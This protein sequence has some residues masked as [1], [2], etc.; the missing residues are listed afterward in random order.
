MVSVSP[1]S[2][3]YPTPT[4][5]PAQ[6]L[7]AT[8][9]NDSPMDLEPPG[10]PA[11]SPAPNGLQEVPQGASAAME[12]NQRT[13][14]VSVKW[15]AI[16]TAPAPSQQHNPPLKPV[17]PLPPRPTDSPMVPTPSS[18]PSLPSS[19]PPKPTTSLS[20]PSARHLFPLPAP[21][22][23]SSNMAALPE[24]ADIKP[25]L[26][27]KHET[28]SPPT[29]SSLPLKPELPVSPPPQQD[30]VKP[31]DSPDSS[32]LQREAST[33]TLPSPNPFAS[34]STSASD[35]GDSSGRSTPR[36]EE[37]VTRGRSKSP[38]KPRSGSAD[39]PRKDKGKKVKK[40]EPEAQLIGH[41]PN[42]NDEALSSFIEV[43]IVCITMVGLGVLPA[44]FRAL[45]ESDLMSSCSTGF[46]DNEQACGE[47]SSC[48]NRLMQ[49]ECV[50]GDCK[51]GENCQNQ[52]FQ[53]KQYAKIDIVKTEKKGYG[54]RTSEDLPADTFVYE[55]VGEVIG[56]TAFTKRMKDYAAGGI[57]HFYFM[58]LDRE[59]FIDATKKGGKGR[60]LNHSC[61]PN[62]FVAKWT[63][64]KKMRMGI[65]TKRDIK[66][67]EE[68]TFNYNVDRYGHVAQPCYCG[69][70]NCVGFI[71]GKTQT[72]IGGMDDLY[73]D[74]LGITEEVE[75]LGLR[76][77]KK[78]KSKKLD[79]DFLPDLKPI[80]LDE[81]PKVSAAVRQAI[82][83]RRILEKLLHRIQ[84]T[85]DEDVRNAL[86]RL[87]GF[88]L[89][90]HILKEYPNDIRI[91]TLDL[92]ILGNW[93]LKTR[94]K[95][96]D[97]KI[98][99][100]VQRCA[101]MME[102][103]IS[104]MATAVSLARFVPLPSRDADVLPSHQLL[105]YWDSLELG[106]R[107]P[108]SVRHLAA[109]RARLEEPVIDDAALRRPAFVKPE[110]SI[111]LPPSPVLP[112]GWRQHHDDT[113]KAYYENTVSG[114]VQWAAP[115]APAIEPVVATPKAAPAP[116]DI[117]AIIAQAQKEAEAVAA[118]EAA[119]VEEE[120]RAAK[121]AARKRAGGT[122]S[123]RGGKV[124][125]ANKEKKVMALF[126]T[127][128]VQ[129]MSKYRG[130]LE[131]EQFKKRAREVTTLLCEKEKKHPLYAT[132]PYDS[133]SAE[134]ASKVKAFTKDWVKKLLDRKRASNGGNSGTATPSLTTPSPQTPSAAGYTSSPFFMPPTPTAAG[135]SSLGND[136]DTSSPR[137]PAAFFR[138]DSRLFDAGPNTP[139][140]PSST[141]NGFGNDSTPNGDLRR[142]S[143]ASSLG[144]G[145]TGS[146]SSAASASSSRFGPGGLN[147]QEQLE[148]IGEM[149]AAVGNGSPERPSLG[150][151]VA[152]GMG[153]E[154]PREP[155][156]RW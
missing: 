34:T 32:L 71:G 105:D 153:G 114:E 146:W 60:F 120:R 66:A 56:P 28:L 134:K 43:A 14:D 133:L 68:L 58:A 102:E 81:V 29:F 65:F 70:A 5:P 91:I 88:N 36:E 154:T 92:E 47:D 99:P 145:R 22:H 64:G 110:A 124:D 130:H 25:S 151:R 33:S 2:P 52:R 78:K 131:P 117:N 4:S 7:E 108:R 9:A 10:A 139:I 125:A 101:D 132:E 37:S 72:D 103:R 116:I 121:D 141:T 16:P 96:E 45:T 113:G 55:Y 142:P 155:S 21:P 104:K 135:P 62:C 94:N 150:S 31:F 67:D 138:S 1:S 136:Y 63:I 74:A 86:L 93:T 24:A 100:S 140:R 137:Y 23:P 61:N 144:D 90:S 3:S 129:V 20:P 118:K 147:Q 152:G 97:S 35:A 123:G 109:K 48:M 17:F 59:V 83:T 143:A 15:E 54:V 57:R 89:M 41:L 19:L 30:D 69:E 77:T 76:G 38:K 84:M 95:V 119:K 79:E 40:E 49:I 85:T 39:S 26:L 11:R 122:P 42:A 98:E 53:R 149:V 12:V 128:V 8:S 107:I 73:I 127:I 115:T 44:L 156:A 27:Y 75:A 46:P 111:I 106:Y 51:C 126:S 82:Q 13:G 148:F 87:H 50:Q 80:E 112:A 6:R 18:F